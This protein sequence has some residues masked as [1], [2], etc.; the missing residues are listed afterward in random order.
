MARET[1]RSG[2]KNDGQDLDMKKFLE[3]L[4]NN[5][6]NAEQFEDKEDE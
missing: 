4:A 5:T 2:E 3:E 1:R 6:P